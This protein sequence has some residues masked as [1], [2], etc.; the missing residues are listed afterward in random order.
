MGSGDTSRQRRRRRTGKTGPREEEGA[1]GGR[2]GGGGA[3]RSL[4]DAAALAGAALGLVRVVG[5][6]YGTPY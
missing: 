4:D 1:R 3:W 6:R 5:A 2:G